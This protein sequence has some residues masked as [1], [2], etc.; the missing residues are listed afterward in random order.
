MIQRLEYIDF[1]RGI[2]I[3]LVVIGHLIQFNGIVTSNPVFE[4]IYSFHMPLFFAIS[5]YIT[6]KVTHIETGKQYLLYLKKKSIG[7]ATDMQSVAKKIID[8]NSARW[9]RYLFTLTD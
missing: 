4:F 1:C 8:R 2:A 5:G 9:E 6:Q 7:S 3:L